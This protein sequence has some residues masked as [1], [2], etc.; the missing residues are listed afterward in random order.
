MGDP[1]ARTGEKVD[2]ARVQ[3]DA[4]GVPDIRARPSE[5]LGIL[6]RPTAEVFQRIGDVLVVLGEVG[7]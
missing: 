2:F 3:L 1:C 5:L 7:V 6:A 4:M